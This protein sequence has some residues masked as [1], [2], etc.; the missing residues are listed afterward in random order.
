[1]IYAVHVTQPA[2]RDIEAAYLWQR[3]QTITA[4][5]SW[6]NALTKAVSTLKQFPTRCPLVPEARHFEEPI[7]QL[8]C[9]KPPHVYRVLFVV[10]RRH[11]YV[12]HV[13]HRA[14]TTLDLHDIKLT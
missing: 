8:L 9:G 2:R 7:R 10:H 1:M 11:V 12:L 14:R 13:R 6:F 4:A 3:Q 5:V